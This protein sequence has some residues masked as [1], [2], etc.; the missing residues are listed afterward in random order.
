MQGRVSHQAAQGLSALQY[1]HYLTRHYL[2]VQNSTVPGGPMGVSRCHYRSKAR[3]GAQYARS[4]HNP[5]RQ[6]AWEVGRGCMHRCINWQ[7]SCVLQHQ[8]RAQ[9]H[10]TVTQY[11][12]TV[13]LCST[14]ASPRSTREIHSPKRGFARTF[15]PWLTI[16][17]LSLPGS[18]HTCF[19]SLTHHPHA[20]PP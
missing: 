17:M 13:Q 6:I 9:L 8:P 4:S 19:P 20:F 7:Y 10:S 3:P 5:D 15:P 2:T 11:S 14:V 16:H 1:T 12:Y 18:P